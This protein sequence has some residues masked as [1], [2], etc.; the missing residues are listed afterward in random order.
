MYYRVAIA[1]E[2]QRYLNAETFRLIFYYALWLFES[3]Y[4]PFLLGKNICKTHVL[5]FESSHDFLNVKGVG[6]N[7]DNLLGWFAADGYPKHFG[8]D[9]LTV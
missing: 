1:V 8:V 3:A 7:T 9:P 4:Y 5:L 6:K 2:A